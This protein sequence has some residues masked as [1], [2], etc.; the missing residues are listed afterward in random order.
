MST[1]E[2]TVTVPL[3]Q[4]KKNRT[5]LE[6]APIQDGIYGT[7]PKDFKGSVLVH[8]RTEAE[9]LGIRKACIDETNFETQLL[10]YTT[11]GTNYNNSHH[12]PSPHTHVSLTTQEKRLPE[13]TR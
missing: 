12:R 7:H 6:F 3:V 10:I 11:S 4:T 9:K 2:A 8:N 5:R 1:Q 13:V